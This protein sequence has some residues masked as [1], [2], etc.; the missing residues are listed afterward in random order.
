MPLEALF[1]AIAEAVFGYL[2]QESGLAE[3]ARAVLGLDPERRAFQTALAEV[4]DALAHHYSEWTAS[5]QPPAPSRTSPAGGCERNTQCAIRNTQYGIRNTQ[6]GPGCPP[7]VRVVA[8]H[9]VRSHPMASN[10]KCTERVFGALCVQ[11][12][13]LAINRRATQ[14][15]PRERGWIGADATPSPVQC[16]ASLWDRARP[17]STIHSWSCG[18]RRQDT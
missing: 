15:T 4:Y 1:S 13:R 16:E 2:L 7:P 18:R 10:S 14:A 8:G 6:Y 12:G 3:R 9:V 17:G 11:W 5:L